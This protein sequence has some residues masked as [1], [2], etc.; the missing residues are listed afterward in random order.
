MDDLGVPPFME[1]S[2]YKIP[3]TLVLA[4]L[5]FLRYGALFFVLDDEDQYIRAAALKVLVKVGTLQKNLPN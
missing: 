3:N 2:K 5:P 1:T 4:V